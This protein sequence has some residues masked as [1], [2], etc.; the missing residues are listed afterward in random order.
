MARYRNQILLSLV[1]AAGSAQLPAQQAEAH[2][3]MA[4]LWRDGAAKSCTPDAKACYNRLA[5]YEDCVAKSFLGG[6][7]NCG[8]VPNGCSSGC[9]AAAQAAGAASINATG[10]AEVGRYA[11]QVNSQTQTM[12]QLSNEVN[13]LTGGILAAYEAKLARE[14]AAASAQENGSIQSFTPSEVTFN[15]DGTVTKK[16]SNTT[17]IPKVVEFPGTNGSSIAQSLTDALDQ[18]SAPRSRSGNGLARSLTNAIDD[19]DSGSAP[20]QPNGIARNL[21]NALDAMDGAKPSGSASPTPTIASSLSS[22]LDR[23]LAAGSRSKN[24]SDSETLS[25]FGTVVLDK[26]WEGRQWAQDKVGG[27][28]SGLL[29]DLTKKGED[30]LKDGE[31]LLKRAKDANEWVNVGKRTANGAATDED[32]RK[33]LSALGKRLQ[34]DNKLAELSRDEAMDSGKSVN[35]LASKALDFERNDTSGETI[36]DEFDNTTKEIGDA[37]LRVAREYCRDASPLCKRAINAYEKA[38]QTAA[39]VQLG[40]KALQAV[41]GAVSKTVQDFWSRWQDSTPPEQQ[42]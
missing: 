6:S 35:K 22:A 40:W 25:K 21:T 39:T 38:Q 34:P 23:E 3:A 37:P 16:Y 7:G 32:A 42:E 14:E 17:E 2:Q 18:Q 12:Q 4:K 33:T 10:R 19:M 24:N 26:A 36:E 8:N 1:V 5:D 13:R 27:L 30:A 15:P 11:N 31:D 41:P 29:I 9:G 28:T 20:R